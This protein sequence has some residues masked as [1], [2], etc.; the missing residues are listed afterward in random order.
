[1]SAPFRVALSGDFRKPDGSPVYPDFD[2]EPLRQ[3]P[4]V[5]FA[6]LEL[7]NPVEAD[8]LK[9]FDELIL[10]A[11]HF[12]KGRLRRRP[13]EAVSRPQIR[14]TPLLKPPGIHPQRSYR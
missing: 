11:H 14:K 5:G 3:A 1:M 6:H 7:R 13:L 10:L 9:D 8:Q 4:N 12:A 2:V